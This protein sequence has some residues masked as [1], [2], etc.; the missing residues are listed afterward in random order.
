MHVTHVVGIN[1]VI[2]LTVGVVMTVIFT[3][4]FGLG[5][6]VQVPIDTPL[7]GLKHKPGE[8]ERDRSCSW[9]FKK[10]VPSPW[11]ARWVKNVGKLQDNVCEEANRDRDRI[12]EW[13]DGGLRNKESPPLT[14]PSSTFS[15]FY[16]VND[17]TGEELTDYI[18]PL[19][20]LT[21]HPFFCLKTSEANNIGLWDFLTKGNN[22]ADSW[23]VNKDYM[24]PSWNVSR[25]LEQK[26]ALHAPRAF[27]F[28]LGASYYDGG[29]GGPSQSWFV[30]SYEMRGVVWKG[31]FAWEATPQDPSATWAAIPARLK[32]HY[33]W[34]NI[35][36]SS[37]PGHADNA[38]DYIRTVARR[39]DYVLLKIDIDNNPVETELVNQ[40][41]A[42]DE[43]IGLVDEIYFE[44]H[45][46]VAP[47]NKYWGMQGA[48]QYL[49]DTYA[50]FTAFRQR[51]VLAHSW[52]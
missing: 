31:V 1:I 34:Y 24:I 26:S 44:H 29:S 3:T 52:V 45:V 22:D 17:C 4:E 14:L 47:M 40:L 19:A 11:E 13:V 2:F 20:G 16:F 28:D 48:K 33:H 30:E 51:G 5:N 9:V 12:D 36:V 10:Y 49:S 46:N 43:L 50:I 15:Q 27:F 18:E 21:R 8:L 39:N 35:P 38:L 37:V 6:S 32:P 23:V 42:S 7:L 41:L 25:K